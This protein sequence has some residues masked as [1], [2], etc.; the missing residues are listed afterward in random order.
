MGNLELF[1]RQKPNMSPAAVC[2]LALLISLCS[3]TLPTNEATTSLAVSNPAAPNYTATIEIASIPTACIVEWNDEFLGITPFL[4]TV[5]TNADR[6]W[7]QMGR[8]W[9][10]LQCT[11]PSGQ[12]DTRRWDAGSRIPEKILFRPMG[13]RYESVFPQPTTIPHVW[14][15]KGNPPQES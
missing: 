1:L 8:R 9:H 14:K 5:D 15:A 6:I 4:L 11:A 3:C 2:S 7:R 12:S 13:G 10:I